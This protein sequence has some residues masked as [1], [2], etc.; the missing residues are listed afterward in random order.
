VFEEC[1]EDQC[2]QYI[3]EYLQVENVFE[4]K[5]TEDNNDVQI[6]VSLIDLDRKY[7]ENYYCSNC[8]LKK[9]ADKSK[10]LL[11]KLINNKY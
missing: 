1:T 2:I 8:V 6:T 7:V 3:Q 9:L 10:I 11:K 5:I 4:L